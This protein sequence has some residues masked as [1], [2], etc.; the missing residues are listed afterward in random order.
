[1][2]LTSKIEQVVIENSSDEIL[3]AIK[4]FDL[5]SDKN[6]TISFN[7]QEDFKK[8]IVNKSYGHSIANISPFF[9]KK[10]NKLFY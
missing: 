1:M 10:Y 9:F 8:K 2:Y 7:D 4:E 6:K 5:L 3:E